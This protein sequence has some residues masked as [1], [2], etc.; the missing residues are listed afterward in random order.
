MFVVVVDLKV[1]P[2][3]DQVEVFWELIANQARHS[4]ATEPG[5]HQFDVSQ[6]D[7]DASTF[8][9]YEVYADAAAYDA[10]V[11]T[12][13]YAEFMERAKPMMDGEPRFRRFN[14]SLTNTA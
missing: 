5:C 7:G 13:R 4:V 12:E 1:K 6:A 14:R 8:L 3:P 2:D 11:Q 10:H 9:A